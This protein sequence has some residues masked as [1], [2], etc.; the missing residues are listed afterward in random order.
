MK[1][2][3]T[4][5]IIITSLIALG[6]WGIWQIVAPNFTQKNNQFDTPS[7]SS[8]ETNQS[9][10]RELVNLITSSNN[11]SN[12][13][14][15]QVKEWLEQNNTTRAVQF[16]NDS[17]DELDSEQLNLFKHAFLQQAFKYSDQGALKKAQR[18]L[19]KTTELFQEV[20]VFDLLAKVSIDLQDWQSALSALLKSTLTESRPDVLIDK[21]STLANVASQRKSEFAASSDLESI[22]KL[23]Q[24][25]YDA[26]PS[27]SYFQLE[28][29]FSHLALNDINNA[30]P[31]LSAIQYD[32]DV[33]T[34]AQEQLAILNDIDQKERQA[35]INAREE[36]AAKRRQAASGRN[37]ISV[38]LIRAGNSFLIDTSIENKQTRLLLDTGA[39]ITS[40]SPEVIARLRLTPTGNSIRL[41]T[42]NGITE[43]QLYL[44][45]RV[46]LG[47]FTIEDLV[48]AE[49]NLGG[50]GRFEGL[51][52][53]DLLNKV[54]ENYSY[55][56]DNE[57]NQLIFRRKRR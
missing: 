9:K 33:G 37:D 20:D 19:N 15:Q 54:G 8:V 6:G 50:S 10:P 16:I 46:K 21:L 1:T 14:L 29:A 27:Y 31:L 25:L 23:Y 39:S 5:P 49:V 2:N 26:H 51:L 56:I 30:K 32:L 57:N 7:Q 41:S 43:S 53:T 35:A 13:D 36:L 28:L 38:S 3:S 4:F 55:L 18:L 17:Y 34:Q 40:L 24:S 42:A 48:V 47:R 52:G 12:K 11:S 44:A 22:R 45:R